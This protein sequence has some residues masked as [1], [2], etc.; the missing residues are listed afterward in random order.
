MNERAIRLAAVC[1]L[2]WFILVAGA[3]I[4]E[5]DPL[6]RIL[7]AA[8]GAVLIA[9]YLV[10]APRSADRSDALVLL[11][12]VLFAGAGV[13]SVFAR[14]SLDA[15]VAGL[16]YAAALFHLR[17]IMANQEGRALV[18]ALMRALS[19]V[20]T[21][22]TASV[23]FSDAAKWMELTGSLPPIG[24]GGSGLFW[25]HRYD[26]VLLLLLLYPSW[27]VGRIT[28]VRAGLG[29]MM[30]AV[31]AV[32]LLLSGSRTLWLSTI[33][34]SA[35]T[36]APLFRG[37]VQGRARLS[38]ALAG[39]GGLA[40]T[41]GWVTGVGPGAVARLLSSETLVARGDMWAILTQ[42]WLQHPLGGYGPGSFPWVLQTT[43]YFDTNSWAPRHPD[44]LLFQLLPEAGLLGLAAVTACVA[45]FV[46]PVW[47]SGA[48]TAIW[49]LVCVG[50]ASIGT[51]PADFGFLIVTSMV[52]VAH[53]APRTRTRDESE[54]RVIAR[55]QSL[56]RWGTGVSALVVFAAMLAGSVAMLS[57][58]SARTA[59]MRGSSMDARANLD[60]AVA[61]DPGMAL[62]PRERGTLRLL[63]GDVSGA[64]ID[65]ELAAEIN[66]LDDLTLR[67]LA[68]ARETDGEHSR[69]LAA[70]WNAAA[71]Q[72]S[73]PTNLLLWASLTRDSDRDNAID[74]LAEVVQAWPG[75]TG[76]PSWSLLL[77]EGATTEEVVRLAA[78]RWLQ[79]ANSPQPPGDQLAWLVALGNLPAPNES[80]GLPLGQPHTDATIAALRCDGSA[81]AFL[82]A[83]RDYSSPTYWAI[84]VRDEVNRGNDAS[85]SVEAHALIASEALV[86]GRDAVNPLRD[87]NWGL[88]GTDRW[89]Y[90]RQP[91]DWPPIGLELPSPRSGYVAWLLTPSAA[92][93][94]SG[95]AAAVPQC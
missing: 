84:R 7:N 23:W 2:A 34:A 16:A 42:A 26:L 31:L 50:V 54:R 8:L 41:A 60:L 74:L 95:L 27:W 32:L 22:I 94:E 5:P 46:G 1:L 79:H 87:T 20:L 92:L 81:S 80:A 24:L 90:R 35:V 63:T 55:R 67:A 69:A 44:N 38:V 47:R 48:K 85:K 36:V 10:R 40:L 28:P 15:T 51:N 86:I 56:V 11:A 12:V 76:A 33:V 6:V 29:V 17:G 9:A 49:G 30:G 68:I 78:D 83:S 82:E 62:Y 13:L 18:M 88:S 58:A 70:V 25:G 53:A 72:R 19:V 66:Q 14:Q 93:A 45:A 61:L 59:L 4:W 37:A 43:N 3:P 52:W 64:I 71:V 39:L 57:Y 21:M 73:D 65:L 77:P 89:G 75:T 91:V